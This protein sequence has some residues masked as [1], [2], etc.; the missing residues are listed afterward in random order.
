MDQKSL[1]PRRSVTSSYLLPEMPPG[2]GRLAEL[3]LDLRWSWYHKADNIWRSINETLWNTTH[4]PWLILHNCSRKRFEQLSVDRNFITMLDELEQFLEQQNSEPTWFE[5]DISDDKHHLPI[6]YLSMEFGLSESLPI[7][8]GGLGI[9]AGDFLK[10]ANDLGLPLSGV[11]LLYQQGYLRQELGEEGEQIEQYPFNDPSQL[12]IAPFHDE[13]GEWVRV[14]VPIEDR[15]VRLR[16]WEARVGRVTLYLLDSND[17]LNRPSDRSITSQL[18][19]THGELRLKQEIILGIGGWRLLKQLYGGECICH[20]NEGHPAFAI[21]ERTIDLMRRFSLD[22]EQALWASRSSNIFTTHTP[23]AAGFDGFPIRWIRRYLEPYLSESKIDFHSFCKLGQM[24]SEPADKQLF[25]MAAM[26]MRGSFM[27]NAVS[28]KHGMVSKTLFQPQFP[29]WPHA[30]VPVDHVTNGVHMPSWDSRVADKLWTKFCGQNRWRNN[31]DNMI[32]PIF[33]HLDDQTLLDFRTNG[34]LQLIDYARSCIKHE[35]TIPVLGKDESVTHFLDSN[36][37]TIGFAR[38]FTAY[39]RP[40]LL[41]HDP[42]RLLRLMTDTERPLQLIVAGKAHPADEHGK[43]MIREWTRFA[44]QSQVRG[45]CIFIFDYDMLVAEELVQGVDLWL[46]TPLPPMEACGTSG[47]KVL[48]NGGLN[49]STL[50]G[51]WAEAYEPRRGWVLP[52]PD[53]QLSPEQRNAADA[54]ALYHLLEHE[55]IPAFYTRD[56]N[57]LPQGWIARMRASM[58]ELSP[59]FHANRMLREYWQDFYTPATAAYLERTADQ[60]HLARELAAWQRTI[61]DCWQHVRFGE[62]HIQTSDRYHEFVA[63]VYLDQLSADNIRVSLYA[64]GGPN[65]SPLDIPM[66]IDCPLIG[67]INGYLYKAKAPI[68]RPE[69]N[70]T[71][72]IIPH[73]PK[74]RIPVENT[75]ILWHHGKR[76][77][78]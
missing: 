68:E 2:L 72:R 46:N 39:K 66:Q 24:F 69:W 14:K 55:I 34:R 48:V 58:T 7:Y 74:V 40:D 16:V 45:R 59:R 4:N 19:P 30:E 29:D 8:S 38:R 51:W 70:F 75:C 11:G 12:P 50:D 17:P 13:N 63:E 35:R 41:L 73:H 53:S 3:A 9:L 37:L 76:V 42:S 18:Y 60:A 28:R 57:N 71:P 23:V 20:L 49:L 32:E 44:S 6:G 52:D 15:L 22:F 67:A 54:E 25:S 1:S 77:C 27:V 64:E 5:S 61:A 78:Q 62:L 43:N 21:L 36:T 33:S 65:V 56:D 10:S 31:D 26:A 47:M